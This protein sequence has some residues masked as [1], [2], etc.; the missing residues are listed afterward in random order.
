[1]QNTE[2]QPN[3]ASKLNAHTTEAKNNFLPLHP[4]IYEI[5]YSFQK[6]WALGGD[7]MSIPWKGI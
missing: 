6:Q 3:Y 1:M 4:S 2:T 5:K 7:N